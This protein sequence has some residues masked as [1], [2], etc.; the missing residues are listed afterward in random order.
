MLIDEREKMARVTKITEET[1]EAKKLV[2]TYTC[3][4]YGPNRRQGS[5]VDRNESDLEE[6]YPKQNERDWKDYWGC[7]PSS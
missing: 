6:P 3:G 2:R 7:I 4:V 1:N 5:K